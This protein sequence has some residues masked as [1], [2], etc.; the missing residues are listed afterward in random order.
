MGSL[1]Y[2]CE[3]LSISHIFYNIF[4]VFIATL[5]DLYFNV[6]SDMIYSPISGRSGRPFPYAT[7]RNGPDASMKMSVPMRFSPDIKSD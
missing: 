5:F 3:N 2:S 7:D 4:T 6:Q 1:S